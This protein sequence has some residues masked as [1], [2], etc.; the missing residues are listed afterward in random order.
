MTEG[1]LR[2]ALL[3]GVMKPDYSYCADSTASG[4]KV[5]SNWPGAAEK[6]AA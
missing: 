2:T 6:A 1:F 4:W 3:H 5:L